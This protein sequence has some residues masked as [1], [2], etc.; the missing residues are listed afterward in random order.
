VG[1]S[2]GAEK[3]HALISEGDVA[4]EQALY[5]KL[6]QLATTIP[7]APMKTVKDPLSLLGRPGSGFGLP[8]FSELRLLYTGA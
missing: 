1:E 4:G 6:T 8:S 3:S 7:R 2:A 5:P